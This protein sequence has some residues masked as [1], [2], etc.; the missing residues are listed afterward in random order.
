MSLL[1]SLA[2]KAC[3]PTNL[4]E[5]K[6]LADKAVKGAT[7]LGNEL[8]DKAKKFDAQELAAALKLA[9]HKVDRDSVSVYTVDNPP[10]VLAQEGYVRSLSEPVLLIMP[11]LGYSLD[12]WIDLGVHYGT[13]VVIVATEK[14]DTSHRLGSLMPADGVVVVC[15]AEQIGYMDLSKYTIVTLDELN[16]QLEKKA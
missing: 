3:I 15:M 9:K 1:K 13:E 5:A 16:A 10:N 8:V 11:D 7:E 12:F 4:E 6:A 2:K 14:P